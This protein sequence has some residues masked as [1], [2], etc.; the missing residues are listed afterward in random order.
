MKAYTYAGAGGPEVLESQA[1]QIPETED[2]EVLIEVAAFGLNRADVQQ[3]KGVYPPPPGAS[4]IPGLEVSG[5]VAKVGKKVTAWNVGD[6]V[7]A[8]LAGGGYAQYVNVDSSHV[9]AVPAQMDLVEAAGLPE[10]A[11]TVVSNIF[12]EGELKEGETI[13]IHGGSGGIG[14]MAIQLA[15]AAGATVVV[16]ASSEDK[17][18]Y[19]KSLGADE[20]INYREEDVLER[21]RELTG[22]K[23][24]DLILDVVGAKYLAMNLK[25]L[26][27]GGR[28][29]VI[30]LQGGAKAE[31][32]LRILMSKRA[33]VIGTTLRA[34]PANEKTEIV[35]ETEK[36]IA[37]LLAEGKLGLNVTKI[38]DFDSLVAAHEHF[39]SGTHLGKIVVRA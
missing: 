33:R 6:R 26:A 2:H 32:D 29:V 36:R 14:S 21:V 3:R 9:L 13:L 18:A 28:M 17:I 19:C 35:K 34:R 31:L 25:A 12:L 4:D 27:V 22:A 16:T 37:P 8:L 20:G 15:K 23:G 38:Y 39:D 10:V 24:V 5:T 1:R 11:A 30:G 7:A